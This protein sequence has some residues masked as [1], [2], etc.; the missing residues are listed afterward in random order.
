M[1]DTYLHLIQIGPVQSFIA[2]ARR[3]QDLYVGS[4]LLS[5][6]AGA[7]VEAAR[8]E[9]A[10][11]LFPVPLPDG[12]LPA[13]VPHRFA[14]LS[15]REP[16]AV[17]A[18]VEEA[19]RGHWTNQIARPV[20]EWLARQAGH[21]E[22]EAMFDRQV[23]NWLEFYSVAVPYDHKN[24]GNSYQQAVSALNARKQARH[25]PQ[26]NEPDE[27][28]TLTGAQAALPK[29][30]WDALRRSPVLK[31]YDVPRPD[32]GTDNIVLRTNE[33]LGALAAIKRFAV[34]AGVDLGVAISPDFD[35]VDGFPSTD[36]VAGW[37]SNE[38]PD[39]PL[40]L[41]VLHM[42]GDRM[43]KL[44][45]AQHKRETHREISE[46]LTSFAQ[47][48]YGIVS[49]YDNPTTGR[50]AL[51]YAGG[52]DV[53]ALLPLESALQCA[54]EIQKAFDRVMDPFASRDTKGEK[55]NGTM[56]AGIAI[57]AAH[58][59]LDH[60]LEEARL[61]EKRA[62]E[63]YGRAAVV[64][65]DT[66][67]SAIREMGAPWKT[68]IVPLVNALQKGIKAEWLSGKFGY[69][70]LEAARAMD[71]VEALRDA[72]VAEMERLLKRHSEKAKDESRNAL[73]ERLRKWVNGQ[74]ALTDLAHWVIL[75]RF[76]VKGGRS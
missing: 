4:R 42:D 30:L 27:K 70:L 3:T 47:Q 36:A 16:K 28:C 65:R 48:V 22:W 67:S 49:K 29:A 38:K 8:H 15:D 73:A 23:A 25:F 11:L 34:L 52:D 43:G 72:W 35:A 33:Q 56:S 13:G 58:L 32:G 41:A 62:K 50:S 61:A 45:S 2:A 10:D 37:F 69:D 14:F 46:R 17:A 55:T 44:L 31:R 21:G 57:T 54:D 1:S 6:L 9:G 64:V 26:V 68:E 5:T 63:A 60:G 74:N 40:Y 76:L 39:R 18:K 19:I 12:S 71:G 59:P 51:V 20:R 7:G 53:L 75:V 66:R 24:H